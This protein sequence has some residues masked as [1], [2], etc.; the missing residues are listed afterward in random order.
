VK[1]P[2]VL[3]PGLDILDIG[4]KPYSLHSVQTRRDKKSEVKSC[5]QHALKLFASHCTLTLFT[6]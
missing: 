2:F 1:S 5:T 3:S 4:E 6:S